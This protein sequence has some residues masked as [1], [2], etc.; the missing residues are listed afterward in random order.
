MDKLFEE[1]MMIRNRKK[2]L[3]FKVFFFIFF[4]IGLASTAKV[5]KL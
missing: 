2:K 3:E 1:P 5:Y 4:F